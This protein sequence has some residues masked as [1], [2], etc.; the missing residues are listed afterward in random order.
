MRRP[1]PSARCQH[2]DAVMLRL[3]SE[4][5]TTLLMIGLAVV[6]SAFA[7]WIIAGFIGGTITATGYASI[8]SGEVIV[9]AV[10]SNIAFIEVSLTVSGGVTGIT[11]VR[12]W[13]NDQVLSS[14]LCLDCSTLITPQF[15][16]SRVDSIHV[17]VVVSSPSRFNI[18]DYVRVE[19]EYVTGGVTKTVSGVFRVI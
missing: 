1:H 15:P 12:V 8:S 9:N 2:V 5:I 6:A 17:S 4:A 13:H 18:G 7:S 19:I 14:I 10:N 11:N 3:V 16:S